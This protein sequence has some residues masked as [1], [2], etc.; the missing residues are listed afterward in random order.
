MLSSDLQVSG[1]KNEK[2]MLASD[3]RI[4][5]FGSSKLQSQKFPKFCKFLFFRIIRRKSQN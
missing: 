3:L 4:L 1:E 5:E 2:I